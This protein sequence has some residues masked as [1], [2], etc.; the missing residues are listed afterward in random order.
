M[1][2]MMMRM[3]SMMMRIKIIIIIII[4]MSH[5]LLQGLQMTDRNMPWREVGGVCLRG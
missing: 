5:W 3:M 4:Q 1:M 2:M